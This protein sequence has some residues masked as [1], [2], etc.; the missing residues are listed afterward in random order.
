MSIVKNETLRFLI[1]SANSPI[2]LYSQ[3]FLDSLRRL[4]K[5]PSQKYFYP[6]TLK[7]K[8]LFYTFEYRILLDGLS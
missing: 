6:H 1:K 3:H 8:V 2:V 7:Y 4:E 5:R